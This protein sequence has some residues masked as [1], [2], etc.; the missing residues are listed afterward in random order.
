MN[1]SC[2]ICM[3]L[4][5][6]NCA[7]ATLPCGH[8]FHEACIKRWHS[9]E[10]NCS[11]CRKKCK[12]EEISKL[13]ISESESAVKSTDICTKY[14]RKIISLNKEIHDLK[15]DKQKVNFSELNLKNLRLTAENARLQLGWNE[16]EKK[17]FT[18]NETLLESQEDNNKLSEKLQD[19]KCHEKQTQNTLRNEIDAAFSKVIDIRSDLKMQIAETEKAKREIV[20]LEAK[21]ATPCPPRWNNKRKQQRLQ[22]ESATIKS[23]PKKKRNETELEQPAA[24][25]NVPV[26]TPN[27]DY[28]P[29]PMNIASSPSRSYSSSRSTSGSHFRSSSRSS[30]IST[31]GSRF[32]SSACSSSR[33]TSSRSQRHSEKSQTKGKDQKDK[34]SK[35]SRSQKD[36]GI[37]EENNRIITEKLKEFERNRQRQRD[38]NEQEQPAAD[39]NLPVSTPNADYTRT[40]MNIAS[41]HSSSRSNSRSTSGSHF[42]SPSRSSSIST[43]SRS[44]RPTSHQNILDLSTYL[45]FLGQGPPN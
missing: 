15:V 1:F 40:P 37:D 18:L 20:K 17:C 24:D 3:E 34:Y 10:N 42:R 45:D 36:R 44:Q 31:S 29:T 6:T 13:F 4:F 5:G 14:E 32:H 28:M 38:E 12:A 21:L 33:S 43:S 39:S 2:T 27:A 26:S 35:I 19:L 23:P 7:I 9:A 11:L 41:S 25:S 30:S 8:V 22:D 16:C